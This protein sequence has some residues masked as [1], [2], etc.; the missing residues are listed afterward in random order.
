[1]A[2]PLKNIDPDEA[3]KR[4]PPDLLGAVIR[5]DINAVRQFLKLDPSCIHQID[6]CNNN[7]M[8]LCVGGG[9]TRMKNIMTALLDTGNIDLLSPNLDGRTPLELAIALND[10]IGIDLLYVPTV[11]QL[12]Q[13]FPDPATF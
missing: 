5:M 9:N 3:P 10:G 6:S 1:M 11:D 12:D 7:A 2:E 8:H 13:A 4:E